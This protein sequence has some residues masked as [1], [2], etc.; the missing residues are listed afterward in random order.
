MALKEF[1]LIVQGNGDIALKHASDQRTLVTMKFAADVIDYLGDR[2]VDVAKAMVDA[3]LRKVIDLQE[4]QGL[5]S[6]ATA[7]KSHQVH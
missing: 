2:H 6:K 3:G 4:N 5:L 7:V 1:E